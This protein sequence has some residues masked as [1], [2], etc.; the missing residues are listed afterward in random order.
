MNSPVEFTPATHTIKHGG[1]RSVHP[2]IPGKKDTKTLLRP[3][4]VTPISICA[5]DS[6][7][8]YSILLK[9]H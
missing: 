5:S 9:A 4:P 6:S 3:P 2:N 8:C 1:L 7:V